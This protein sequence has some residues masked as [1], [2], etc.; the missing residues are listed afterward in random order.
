MAASSEPANGSPVVH[1]ETRLGRT[2]SKSSIN[3]KQSGTQYVK[4][5]TAIPMTFTPPSAVSAPS[6]R[7]SPS[8]SASRIALDPT[9][10]PTPALLP[11]T[12]SSPA[13]SP[14]LSLQNSPVP[15]PS[16]QGMSPASPPS[17]MGYAL[18]NSSRTGLIRRLSRGAQNKLTRRRT[19]AASTSIRDQS[20]GPVIIRR[21][22]DSR[23]TSDPQHDVSDL[24]L[25]PCEDE[26]LEDTK[27]VFSLDNKLN[28]L[29]LSIRGNP[30]QH[31]LGGTIAPTRHL[32]LQRGTMLTKVTRKK[33]KQLNF[34]INYEAAKVYWDP[35]KSSKQ[36]YIDDIR[37]LRI[38]AEARNYR[39]EF[40]VPQEFESR[41]F[42]IL[43]TNPNN[44]K[45]RTLKTIHLIAPT[46]TI[47]QLWTTTLDGIAKRRAEIMEGLAGTGER[48][49]KFL[50]RQEM[51]K[52]LGLDHAESEERMSL[53]EV[54]QICTSLHINCSE[55][56]LRAQFDKADVGGTGFLDFSQ[57]EQFVKRLKERKDIKHIF[58]S[59]KGKHSE[60]LDFAHFLEFVRDVQC[61]YIENRAAYWKHVF[62]K[63]ARLTKPRTSSND[64]KTDIALL[65]M[66]LAAFQCFMTSTDN[67]VFVSARSTPLLDRPINEYFISSS[68][69]TYLL[70]WQVAGKS[71]TEAY[72]SVLQKGCRCIEIDCWDG[73]DGRPVVMHGRTLTSKVLFSDCI[74]V[75]AKHAFVS[76]PYPLIISLEVHC[77]PEQ[78]AAMVQIM[79]DKFGSQLL[80]EPVMSNAISLP[81]PEDLKGKILIKVKSSQQ[82]DE[83][84]L[85]RDLASSGSGSGR[86]RSLS[87]PYSQSGTSDATSITTSP[88][89]ASPVSTSPSETHASS[90]WSTQGCST[91]PTSGLPASP[92]SSTEDSENQA[93]HMEERRRRKKTSNIT[94]T[95]G[96]LGVYL[97]GIKYSDF[98]SNESR[99]LNHVF[100]FAEPTVEHLCRKD[101]DTEA[102]LEK[103][104]VRHLMRVY[105]SKWRV[106]STN[107]DPIRYWRRGVQMA[108]LNWQTY[109]VGL[110]INDAMFAAGADRNGYVLKPEGMRHPRS[111]A[112]SCRDLPAK[113]DKK[114]INFTVD[115]I[116]AQQLPRPSGLK[117]ED[118]INP[119]VEFEIFSADDKTRVN[120]VGEGGRD[121]SDPSGMS[122]LGS[123]LRKITTIV[124]S[125]GY[126]PTF[127][128]TLTLNLETRYPELVFVR[129]NI[130]NSTDGKT[131]SAS[132][133][134]PLATFT[135]KL[136]S[137]E[138]GFRHLP[139]FNASGEQYLF[140]TLFV[141]LRKQQPVL[142]SEPVT[143]SADTLVAP[144]SAYA[145]ESSGFFK[146]MLRSPSHRRKNNDTSSVRTQ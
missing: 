145:A 95:L 64:P 136:S 121:A 139:L 17:S 111:D 58:T 22:S 70:G 50:W 6:S 74:E 137:L 33:R 126:D 79:K 134:Q 143:P 35:V 7:T 16:V 63:Y 87:T 92:Y 114:S 102:L 29:G 14:S 48:T 42:S 59:I 62:E 46:D 138:E 72:I 13:L 45:G 135:A 119:Y 51:I 115:I 131:Y 65:T 26:K 47:F 117:P 25:E 3:R 36:F 91:T 146:R 21:R 118:P 81:S 24:E 140:S 98:R 103:H 83:G 76:S 94:K 57:F 23:T 116:S 41:W 129:W 18:A 123:P 40:G 11:E 53:E 125:N 54:R 10:V 90:Y 84:S 9:L 71:S 122:G 96:D 105:P 108:A 1:G 128:E 55:N 100:S 2:L 107:F 61:A 19:S 106:S 80:L 32:Q 49:I 104:N 52:K 75:I 142:S 12:H 78:Q 37:E 77:N 110:Q 5:I 44:S 15:V 56:T 34:Y 39:E 127:E 43:Y 30:N 66:D 27:S 69:N 89:I 20:A 133:R 60:E 38:G 4:V 120:A 101:I 97:R 112:D 8:P 85:L 73:S 82:S 99:T 144:Y 124:Q 28:A 113:I 67:S 86:Q 130:F 31:E 109:D 93:G 88:L 141:R 132:D 68:H